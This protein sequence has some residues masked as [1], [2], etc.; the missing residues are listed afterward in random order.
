M[1]GGYTHEQKNIL[2]SIVYMGSSDDPVRFVGCPVA[3]G[4]GASS[5]KVSLGLV[6]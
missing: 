4:G 1:N 3:D 5:E 6:L 2:H